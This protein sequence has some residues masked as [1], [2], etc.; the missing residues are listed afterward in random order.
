MDVLYC[1]LFDKKKQL[2]L[3]FDKNSPNANYIILYLILL[4]ACAL[5]YQCQM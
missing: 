5:L 2:G 1:K 4:Q 3:L